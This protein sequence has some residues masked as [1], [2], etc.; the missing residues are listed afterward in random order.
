MGR[1]AILLATRTPASEL[2][3]PLQYQVLISATRSLLTVEW[4]KQAF[5][6]LLF[7]MRFFSRIFH[8]KTMTQMRYFSR[9]FGPKQTPA[10]FD[11]ENTNYL[12]YLQF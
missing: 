4:G 8:L 7:C 6:R 11:F 12:I 3:K 10:I 5:S 9:K 1:Y 2:V